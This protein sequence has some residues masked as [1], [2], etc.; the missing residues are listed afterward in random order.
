MPAGRAHKTYLHINSF[1]RLTSVRSRYRV[2]KGTSA[3]TNWAESSRLPQMNIPQNP[4]TVNVCPVFVKSPT[5]TSGGEDRS[6]IPAAAD[7]TIYFVFYFVTVNVA[8]FE[9][10]CAV[11]A[12]NTIHR[13]W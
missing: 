10:T 13:N 6:T 4:L 2:Q 5:N 7:L 1:Q 3:H 12:L 9:I 11:F 8:E